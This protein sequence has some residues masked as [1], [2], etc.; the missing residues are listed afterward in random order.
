LN[1]SAP[2]SDN[3]NTLFITASHLWSYHKNL[4][5]WRCPSDKS[6]SQFDGKLYPRVRSM[7]MSCW[8]NKGRDQGDAWKGQSDFKIIR[9]SSEMINPSPSMTWVLMD[10]REDGINDGL[11]VVNM[12]G[13]D[14]PASGE[15]VIGDYPASYHDG[16]G[17]LN[18]A[19]GHSEIHK[20]KDPRTMPVLKIGQTLQTFV[21]SPNN[22]DIMWLQARSTS[23]I[24]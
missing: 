18:F 9:R 2:V 22:V 21:G 15:L 6:I 23:K 5:V 19:D 12:Y 7:S 10:E 20:W 8:L 13:V 24:K 14:P 16:A 4:S 17:A 3:T 1:N 11:F